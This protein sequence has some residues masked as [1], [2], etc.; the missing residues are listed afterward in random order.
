MMIC[1]CTLAGTD[2]GVEACINCPNNEAYKYSNSYNETYKYSNSLSK[3]YVAGLRESLPCSVSKPGLRIEKEKVVT[4]LFENPKYSN[5]Y[6]MYDNV[7]GDLV[8]SGVDTPNP[9]LLD[10]LKKL[11]VEILIYD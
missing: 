8:L 4:D 7:T 5:T 11:G 6:K 9:A 1:N 3:E 10:Y 2:K